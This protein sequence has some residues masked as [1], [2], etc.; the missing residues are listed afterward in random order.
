MNLPI[1]AFDVMAA[2]AKENKIKAIKWARASGIELSRISEYRRLVKQTK[3]GA[4]ESD[5]ERE[6]CGHTFSLKNFFTLWDGLKRLVGITALRRGLMRQLETR[7]LTTRVRIFLRLMAFNDGH[8]KLVDAFTDAL[9]HRVNTIS[10]R[11]TRRC[12]MSLASRTV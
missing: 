7:K 6:I 9:L 11:M 10:N 12:A 8:L 4:A 3:A 1:S 5:E 2:I